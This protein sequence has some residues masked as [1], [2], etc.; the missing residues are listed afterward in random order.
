MNLTVTVATPETLAPLR[1]RY[2]A[3]MNCQVTKDSI[4]RRPGWTISHLLHANGRGIGYGIRAHAGPWQDK[5][6]VIEFW[7]EPESRAHAF[8]AFEAY[9]R[10]SGVRFFEV[11]SNATLL[12]VMLFT[13]GRDVVSEAIVFA[14]A[15]T[16]TLPANGATLRRTNSE[17]ES[18]AAF[19][20]RAGGTEWELML[21]GRAIGKGGVLFHYN[22]PYGDVFMEIDAAHR[23]RG[24][25]AYFVQELKR[26][27]RE[28]GGIPA[29]RTRPNN[30]AS[31][32]TLQKAGFVPYCHI[33]DG[34]L[35]DMA[36]LA[37]GAAS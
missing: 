21:D 1:A 32:L 15:Y 7:L 12:A 18:R 2:C 30:L 20:E 27:C 14:D 26:V 5:P 37:S 36:P 22:F 35:P 11:Q 4:S 9:A 23:R 28:L 31:R 19:V 6:T 8:V 3:E 17:A 10:A 24:F 34:T 13:Y 33:L 16:T 29:A 25:G